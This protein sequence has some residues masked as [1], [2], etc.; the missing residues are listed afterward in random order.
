[1]QSVFKFLVD[2]ASVNI[3][4]SVCDLL[5]VCA[6]CSPHMI[7]TYPD[8]F[9]L[10]GNWKLDQ[11]LSK[12]IF[13]EIK[14]YGLVFDGTSWMLHSKTDTQFSNLSLVLHEQH[15]TWKIG[16]YVKFSKQTLCNLLS[17]RV[18]RKRAMTWGGQGA[19]YKNVSDCCKLGRKKYICTGDKY[20]KRVLSDV[21]KPDQ[22][23]HSFSLYF[24][25][26]CIYTTDGLIW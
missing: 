14:E 13:Q 25:I 16:V 7:L 1:M 2:I 23:N 22:Q 12:I 18:E 21:N 24:L 26:L 15:V 9:V 8:G 20:S 6:L 5:L 10:M 4:F 3:S 11:K 17:G 19:Q